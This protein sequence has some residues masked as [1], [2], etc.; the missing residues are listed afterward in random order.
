[1][2]FPAPER[3]R[4]ILLDIEGTTTPTT[5]VYN[6][7]FPYAAEEM[8]R[9]IER[10]FRDPATRPYLEQIREQRVADGGPDRPA[11]REDSEKA[12]MD[13]LVAYARWLMERDSKIT[14]LKVLQAQ[15]WEQGYA[16]GELHGQV[17]PDVPPALRRWKAQG[18]RV[19]IYSSGSELAQ[20]LLFQSTNFGDL[21]PLLNGFFD[22]RIGP[23]T[24]T[25]SYLGI[26]RRIS[27]NPQEVLFV[28][29]SSKELE[30]ARL[31]GMSTALAVRSDTRATLPF[32]SSAIHSFDEIFPD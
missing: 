32:D 16:T 9:F 30:A 14:A 17:Y 24:D 31:A 1:M 28:S 5:F 3:I 11:W 13:S 15:I 26:A 7:L 8:N 22:T 20:K 29:D 19:D 6:V 27:Y 10:H 25:Q 21:T 2:P 23:K 18:K 12:Y 4:A